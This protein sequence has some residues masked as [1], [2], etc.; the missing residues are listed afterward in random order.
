MDFFAFFEGARASAGFCDSLGPSYKYKM[1]DIS[2]RLVRRAHGNLSVE[3]LDA[4]EIIQLQRQNIV[5][6]DNL[7]VFSE[8]K[9]LHLGG[10]KIKRIENLSFLHKLEFLDLSFNRID[11][12][13][14][15]CCLGQLPKGL[16]T[17]VLTGNPCCQNMELLG[18]LNDIMP[19]LGIVLGLDEDGEAGAAGVY[20]EKGGDRE[21]EAEE[22]DD[23]DDDEEEEVPEASTTREY[24]DLVL[25][26]GEV[27]NSEEILK[28]IVARKCDQ[29]NLDIPTFNMDETLSALNRECESAV[30]E[31]K[32]RKQKQSKKKVDPRLT[33]PEPDQQEQQKQEKQQVPAAVVVPSIFD[34]SN[35]VF[36]GGELSQVSSQ[37][38][39]IDTYLSN[40]KA[41]ATQTKDFF[42]S[43]R[44]NVLKKRDEKMA[45]AKGEQPAS[46]TTK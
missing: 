10:N 8:I 43:M 26:D 20:E 30:L 36:F 35:T 22:E 37:K 34:E 44:E 29:Q 46:P 45:L 1:T 9:E 5:E 25:K 27:L 41:R 23:K 19:N 24:D 12:E 33:D 38:A 21:D 16:L 13:G 14:L 32:T 3:Q 17:I 2:V 6:I 18:E 11:A 28:A 4:L 15:R 40:S 42:A 31:V 7:E 39:A